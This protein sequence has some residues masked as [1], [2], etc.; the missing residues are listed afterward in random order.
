MCK[1]SKNNL[2]K[3]SGIITEIVEYFFKSKNSISDDYFQKLKQMND[4]D[5]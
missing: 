3:P 1:H 5:G 2:H 4:D